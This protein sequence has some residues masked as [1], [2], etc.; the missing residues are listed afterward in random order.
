MATPIPMPSLSPTMKE[1][2]ITKWLK[3][4]GDKISSGQAIAEVETDKS[5]LEVEAYDDGFLIA[6]LVKEGDSTP[7][8]APIAFIGAKGEKVDPSAMKASAPA[9]AAPT[10]GP[11]AAPKTEA[12]PAKA[13]A[14]A[15]AAKAPAASAA[16]KTQGQVVPLRAAAPAPAGSGERVRASPLARKM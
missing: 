8:G 6:I 16:P 15:P 10:P 1:G 14:P 2:K 4:E 7:V 3:K 12:A 5:N 9:P 11:A 13:S